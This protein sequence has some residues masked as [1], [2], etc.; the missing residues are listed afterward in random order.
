[1]FDCEIAFIEGGSVDFPYVL[2]RMFDVIFLIDMYFC[3]VLPYKVVRGANT[4]MWCVDRC[5]IAKRYLHRALA[6][7]VCRDDGVVLL[8]R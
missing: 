4:A 5:K 7:R 1:M 6:A 8:V 3:F 2:N